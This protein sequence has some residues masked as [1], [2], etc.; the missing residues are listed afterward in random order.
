MAFRDP[1][2]GPSAGPRALVLLGPPG[3][4]KGTQAK[5][6]AQ[7]LGIP[8]LS[9]GDMFREQV[10]RG[11]ELGQR[12][13][14]VMESGGL[15]PDELVNAIVADRL[16]MPDC[17]G[18]F[19]LDGYPRTVAQAGVLD[20]L[21]GRRWSGPVVINLNVEYNELIQRLTGRR[22]CPQCG[23]IYNVLL[24]PPARE[25]LCD[26]DG[27]GLIQRHDDDEKVVR[28]R[29]VAYDALTRPLIDFYRGRDSFFEV[30][31][32]QPPDKITEALY[33]ILGV[34]G[35]RAGA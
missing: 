12:A 10:A 5:V 21:I 35:G 23:S 25:G 11:T 14:A 9:T 27:V 17:Q 16:Q 15:V 30:D 32:S 2:S 24:K 22:S 4:G 28:E 31:G 34:A 8:H 1:K 7:R 33:G 26:R 13:K 29:M 18:G 20:T 6:I 19:L 3:A